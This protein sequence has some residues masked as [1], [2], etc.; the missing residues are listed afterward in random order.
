LETVHQKYAATGEDGRPA[1]FRTPTGRIEL[2]VEDFLDIGQPPL[3]TFTEPAWSHRARP[4]L[5]ARFPLVLTCNKSLHFCETQHRH[6][7]SLR[8]HVPDPLVELHPEAAAAR[9]IAEGDWVEITTPKGAVRAR[10]ELNATLDPSV[11][12][13]QHGWF[14]GCEELDLPAFPPFGPGSANL[15]LVLA[16][17]PSDPV[18]GSSPLR[19]QLCEVAPLP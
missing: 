10:A 18:G 1:G 4:D 12:S 8:K 2:Y 16:Q 15:N 3:P 6:V 7:A 14:T 11:V 5:A 19:A 9:G 17:T 13:G